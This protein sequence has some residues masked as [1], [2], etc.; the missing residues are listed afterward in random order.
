MSKPITVKKLDWFPL[1]CIDIPSCNLCSLIVSYTISLSK[2]PLSLI[3]SPLLNHDP[4]I[5]NGCLVSGVRRGFIQ[6][7]CIQ[8]QVVIIQQI[9]DTE[10]IGH[11]VIEKVLMMVDIELYLDHYIGCKH[12]L[13]GFQGQLAD[14]QVL[15]EQEEWAALDLDYSTMEQ[16]QLRSVVFKCFKGRYKLA[17]KLL[18]LRRASP[19]A[20]IAIC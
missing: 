11:V 13:Q 15:Q 7:G 8:S 6:L 19:V 12:E 18:K 4:T 16:L 3:L 9:V 5:L 17:K 1:T 14:P 20:E 2:V 10:V